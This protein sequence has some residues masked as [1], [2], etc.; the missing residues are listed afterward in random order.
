M[1]PIRV[2]LRWQLIVTAA[3]ALLGMVLWGR[4]GAVSAALGGL[5][6]IAAGWVYGWRVAQGE[7][8]SA[9]E[10]LRTMFRAEALKVLLILVG[11]LVVLKNYKDI[12][13]VAFFA[14]FVITIGV[15]AAAIAVRDTE[16]KNTPRGS[17]DE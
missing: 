13:H 5:I 16:E 3:L 11:L 15:F 9:G 4:D 7:A 12:V 17:R 8:K 6:N 2:V 1:R 14:T 10:A